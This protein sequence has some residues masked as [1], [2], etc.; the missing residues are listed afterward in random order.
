MPYRG[1]YVEGTTN[2]IVTIEGSP[3]CAQTAHTLVQHM[4]RQ[5]MQEKGQ[6]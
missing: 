6:I 2:R 1:D 3:N 5:E 4:I